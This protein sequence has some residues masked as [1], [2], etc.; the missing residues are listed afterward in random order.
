MNPESR[1]ALRG[2]RARVGGPQE[3]GWLVADM[4]VRLGLLGTVV[5]HQLASMNGAQTSIATCET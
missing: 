5:G 1:G 3:N 4:M 2:S